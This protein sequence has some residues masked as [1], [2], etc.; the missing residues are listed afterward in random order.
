[1]PRFEGIETNHPSA[2]WR[3]CKRPKAGPDLRG[4]RP[5]LRR[6]SASHALRPKAGPDLR[7]LRRGQFARGRESDASSE[8][9]PRSIGLPLSPKMFFAKGFKGSF[10][11][12]GGN[13][14]YLSER[15][16]WPWEDGRWG[17]RRMSSSKSTGRSSLKSFRKW[18][19]ITFK[20]E[21]ASWGKVLRRTASMS[22]LK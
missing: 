12:T 14:G 16:V 6:A 4:L 20:V 17:A 18:G 15:R 21:N 11:M 1:R 22:S 5:A 3:C 10:R 8:G 19:S 2:S 13:G 7:G 9:R